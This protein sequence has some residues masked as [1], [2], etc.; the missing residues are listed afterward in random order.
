M[1]MPNPEW[2]RLDA[3][4]RLLSYEGP[5]GDVELPRGITALCPGA[6]R[7]RD[8]IT[9]I[10]L[11]SSLRRLEGESL[12]GCRSLRRLILPRGIESVDS[13]AFQDCPELKEIEL[14]SPGGGIALVN[15]MVLSG[16]M[17]SVRFGLPGLREV[18]IPEGVEKILKQA[19]QNQGALTRV[20]LPDSLRILEESAFE[21]CTGLG[22]IRLPAGLKSIGK[23]AFTGCTGL[24]ELEIP[25]GVSSIGEAAFSG[26]GLRRAVLP[27]SIEVEAEAFAGC[28][29][30][31]MVLHTEMA[32]RYD[33]FLGCRPLRV[34]LLGPGIDPDDNRR[35]PFFLQRISSEFWER[36]VSLWA[37]E[38]TAQEVPRAAKRAAF[39]G[40]L[41]RE[42]AGAEIGRAW[43]ESLYAY[44][45]RRRRELWKDRQYLEYILRQQMLSKDEIEDYVARAARLGDGEITSALLEYQNRLIPPEEKTRREERRLRQEMRSLETGRILVKDIRKE[46]TFRTGADG[47]V[48]LRMYSGT[49]ASVVV[50]AQVGKRAVTALGEEVLSPMASV[51]RERREVRR[52][53]VSVTLPE[54]ITRVG[55]RAFQRCVSLVS[56]KLPSTLRSVSTGMCEGC[57]SLA[58]LEFP[59]GVTE[60]SDWAFTGCSA[61]TEVR[62]PEQ[63]TRLGTDAFRDCTRLKRMVFPSRLEL[64]DRDVCNGCRSLTA[65]TLPLSLK[66]VGERAFQN[67]AGLPA[68]EIPPLVEKMGEDA[69]A[70]CEGLVRVI[71]PRGLGEIPQGCFRDCGKLAEVELPPSLEKIGDRAFWHCSSLVRVELPPGIRR[72][73]EEAF[74]GCDALEEVIIPEGCQVLG[75]AAFRHC[76]NL[77][78]LTLPRSL[79]LVGSTLFADC[80]GVT[81]RAPGGSSACRQA[82][83]HGLVWERLPSGQSQ[84]QSLSVAAGT[85]GEGKTGPGR[86][87]GGDRR[88][89][90][91]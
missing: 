73:G 53:I 32:I 43:E 83:R 65:L 57:T 55:D 4:G 45:R 50:P 1:E 77:R 58:A 52:R 8:D 13:R 81:I 62:L 54:G 20:E 6:F 28:P 56:L 51:D 63:V 68:V 3:Y 70:G 85:G 31:E 89:D 18:R 29:L 66:T 22:E 86:E 84:K 79:S 88:G 37:P 44:V 82:R 5:G 49:S 74:C 71:L 15:G 11:P 60:I 39:R 21:N 24:Q 67:C 61:L 19:F 16:R 26:C 27:P 78:R 47:M 41:E 17:R 42:L 33:S 87:P 69:F 80:P 9:G 90:G 40:A 2:Y 38:L 46:W 7:G 64:I 72:I 30:E 59:E 35:Y 36:T 10:R 48:E 75:M 34:T 91:M 12:G 25:Q 23:R 14:D 76:P